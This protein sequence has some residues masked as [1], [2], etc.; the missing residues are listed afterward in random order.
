MNIRA[1]IPAIQAVAAMLRSMGIDEDDQ[2]FADSIEGETDL[3]E[4]ADAI[5]AK[6][7]DDAALI[8][9]IGAQMEALAARQARLKARMGSSRKALLALLD[10]SGM[11]RMERPAGTISRA[12]GSERVQITDEADIPSQLL[13]VKT[14]TAPDLTAI[15]AH[16]KAGEAVPGAEL[17]R[18][19][20]SVRIGRR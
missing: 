17:V 8:T 19:D 16:L 4:A 11:K 20:D 5:L 12:A 3:M 13:R 15:K 6:E 9:A 7:A 14:T 18:G 2:A 1:N 10:A